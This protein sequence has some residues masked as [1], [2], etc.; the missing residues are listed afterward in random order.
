MPVRDTSPPM[1]CD[2]PKKLKRRDPRK[3][4]ESDDLQSQGSGERPFPNSDATPPAERRRSLD[5]REAQRLGASAPS[6]LLSR[7]RPEAKRRTATRRRTKAPSN[8]VEAT[9]HTSA[10]VVSQPLAALASS[11]IATGV[12]AQNF[13]FLALL[14]LVVTM[15]VFL[16][17]LGMAAK[18]EQAR[19]KERQVDPTHRR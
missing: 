15:S 18:R 8:Q 17:D 14:A 9:K 6:R 3:S 13:R 10:D 11:V 19:R 7:A 16:L 12:V 4:G 2:F 5:R 1:V